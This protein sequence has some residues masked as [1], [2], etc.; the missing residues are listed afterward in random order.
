MGSKKITVITFII[1]GDTKDSSKESKIRNRK[2]V[3]MPREQQRQQLQQNPKTHTSSP[4][5]VSWS[6][7]AKPSGTRNKSSAIGDSLISITSLMPV[8]QGKGCKKGAP[9]QPG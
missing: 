6:T 2:Q 9:H 5:L 7:V 1:M 3:T 8:W 4:N